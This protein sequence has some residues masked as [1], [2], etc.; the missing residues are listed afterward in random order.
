MYNYIGSAIREALAVCKQNM[1][2][3]TPIREFGLTHVVLSVEMSN[4]DE[5]TLLTE[6]VCLKD[7]MIIIPGV[8]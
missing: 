8:S 5:D 7:P 2:K 6:Y 1:L 4:K 3:A